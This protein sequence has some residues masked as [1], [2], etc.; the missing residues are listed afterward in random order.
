LSK[1]SPAA[2]STVRPRIRIVA[3]PVHLDEQSVA[4]AHDQGNVRLNRL[5]APEKRRKQMAFEMVDGEIWLGEAKG[6]PFGKRG[7]DQERT[8]EAGAA[9]GGEG[10]DLA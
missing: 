10:I 6:Q 8:G 4:A 9:R 3:D 1:A 2:S 5:S 7:T